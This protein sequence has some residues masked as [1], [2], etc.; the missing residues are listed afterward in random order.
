M[1]KKQKIDFISYRENDKES[2][3]HSKSDKIE[4]LNS[5]NSD[6]VTEERVA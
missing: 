1:I 6:K 3:M 2:M 4:I 5:D